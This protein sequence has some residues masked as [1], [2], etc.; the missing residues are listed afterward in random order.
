[1]SRAASMVETWAAARRRR[2]LAAGAERLLLPRGTLLLGRVSGGRVT[3]EVR[4]ELAVG[5][6]VGPA[7]LSPTPRGSKPTMS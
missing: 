6:A 1:M 2:L 3:G 7:A 4:V 5:Q